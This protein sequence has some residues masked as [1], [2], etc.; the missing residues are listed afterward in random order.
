MSIQNNIQNLN[1]NINLNKGSYGASPFNP[2][3]QSLPMN[4]GATAPLGQQRTKKGF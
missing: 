2:P 3:N 1:L 4:R